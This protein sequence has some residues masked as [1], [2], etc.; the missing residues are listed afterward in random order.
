[1]S[2]KCVK[3]ELSVDEWRIRYMIAEKNWIVTWYDSMKIYFQF[4][5]SEE[6]K[7]TFYG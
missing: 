3:V 6:I 2:V 4:G 7:K 1:M 5:L